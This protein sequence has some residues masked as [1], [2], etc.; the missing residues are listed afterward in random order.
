[1]QNENLKTGE[2]NDAEL[3]LL[4][5]ENSTEKWDHESPLI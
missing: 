1:M 3:K 2:Q 4:I 5:S